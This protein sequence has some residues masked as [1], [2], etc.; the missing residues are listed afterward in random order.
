[1]RMADHGA[2]ATASAVAKG[3]PRTNA[4][5]SR[6]DSRAKA[7]VS[8]SG[9]SVIPAQRVRTIA[10]R[11]GPDSPA[12]TPRASQSAIGVP[13]ITAIVRLATA[14][15][16]TPISGGMTRCWPNLSASRAPNGPPTAPAR[17]IEAA[18]APAWPYEPV[19]VATSMVIAKPEH[20]H[21]EAPDERR[22]QVIPTVPGWRKIARKAC[23][24]SYLPVGV[25]GKRAQRLRGAD[26]R[27]GHPDQRAPGTRAAARRPRCR[28]GARSRRRSARASTA[29]PPP[30][31]WRRPVVGRR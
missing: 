16:C 9:P 2:I 10:P 28:S 23:I 18:T 22:R 6:V 24:A 27:A 3:G 21:R 30:R 20:R 1:M 12:V 5:S 31:R 26:H 19:S 17:V 14:T 29:G 7:D 4:T 8:S 15:M 25:L 13:A 11:F